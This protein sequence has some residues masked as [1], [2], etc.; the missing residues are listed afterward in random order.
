MNV[1]FFFRIT[2]LSVLLIL[3]GLLDV[4]L[5]PGFSF[6]GEI[7][8]V[9]LAKP[10][11]DKSPAVTS[12]KPISGKSLA[13]TPVIINVD[14]IS[15]ILSLPPV[16]LT[17]Q[18]INERIKFINQMTE[19]A[20]DSKK[21]IVVYYNEA[22]NALKRQQKAVH[23]TTQFSKLMNEGESGATAQNQNLHSLF[24]VG[25]EM[26]AR[27][28]ALSEIESKIVV[29]QTRL[30]EE[31]TNLELT[32]KFQSEI[33]HKP[34]ELRE[35]IKSHETEISKLQSQ[36]SL[37][38]TSNS[39][40]RVIR[41]KQTSLK[42]KLDA[43][44]AELVATEKEAALSKDKKNL[45]ND[46]ISL[47]LKKVDEFKKIIKTW[48]DIKENRQSDLA[49][50][51]I[52]KNKSILTIINEKSF[53]S[54]KLDFLENLC[55]KNLNF[56]KTIISIDRKDNEAEKD[57]VILTERLKQVDTD[58]KITTKRITMMGLTN[59]SGEILLAKRAILSTSYADPTIA[60]KL[61]ENI[62]N[63][64]LSSD[65]MVQE[66]QDFRPFKSSIYNELE[67]LDGKI[68][69]TK[70]L[71][72]TTNVFILLESYR[73]LLAESGKTYTAYLKTLNNLQATQKNINIKSE[74]FRDY[75][76]QRLL[77]TS[78]STTIFKI[79]IWTNS[80]KGIYW[81]VNGY[82]WK[83][84]IKD[85]YKYVVLK[86]IILI[87]ITLSIIVSLLIQLFLPKQIN[88]IN[89][90]SSQPLK[91]SIGRTLSIATLT[92]LQ[93]LC[94]PLTFYLSAL[95]VSKIHSINIFTKAVCFGI[96]GVTSVAFIF[97]L[98]IYFYRKDGICQKNFQWSGKLRELLKKYIKRLFII[99]LPFVFIVVTIQNSPQNLGFR[100][101]LGRLFFILFIFIFLII[102]FLSFK[103][104]KGSKISSKFVEWIQRNYT[105]I[106]I[107][108]ITVLLIL[109]ILSA[110]GYYFTAYE[111]SLN[112]Y[113]T[114][115]FLTVFLFVKDILHRMTYLTQVH[116]AHK[117]A[118]V[119]KKAKQKKKKK[120]ELQQEELTD[121]I[122]VEI[123]D[124]VIGKDELNEQTY[125]L[126][127]F[128]LLI[129]VIIGLLM[130]WSNTFPSIKFLNNVFMWN[131][132]INTVKG[133]KPIM[134]PITLLNLVQG[135]L[136]FVCSIILVKNLP[137]VIEII[138]FR[139][140]DTHPGT[141]HAVILISKY[142]VIC[143]GV[144]V[145]LKFIGIGWAQ[146][147]YIAAALTLGLSFGLQDIFAN[148]VSGIIILIERPIRLGDSVTVAGNTGVI[149]KIRIRSTTITD[150][151]HHELIVP[152]K[153]FLAEKIVNWSLSD[154]VTRIV[155]AVCINQAF[156]DKV[157][158]D[159][160]DNDKDK[161]KDKDKVIKALNRD[162]HSNIDEVEKLLLQV[163]NDNNLVNDKPAPSVIFTGFGADTLDYA[164]RFFVE[165]DK[166]TSVKHKI[167]H[168]IKD[169]FKNAGIDVKTVT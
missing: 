132:D 162:L 26:K 138:V 10:V 6:A 146:F 153:A 116:I 73:K 61:N 164:L 32:L 106:N 122:N 33:I 18:A 167:H 67:K 156:K 49:Y 117:K 50:A 1:C 70:I 142:F 105:W 19:L 87:I 39:S 158:D 100:S 119:E 53:P 41:A 94:I 148:F 23:K 27:S 56:A 66:E 96:T 166:E 120:G 68:S 83:C 51:E 140:K 85:I 20:T 65:D 143:I 157:E 92:I 86:P 22:L 29:F 58:Y 124:S 42:A 128:I 150:G 43:L 79:D 108:V 95:Y 59:K 137:A 104:I 71:E 14:K 121:N 3:I 118:E 9:V 110:A 8:A 109:I 62:L 52:R 38:D 112:I 139:G 115:Y 134:M 35:I 13:T 69:E 57:L 72:L 136:I 25:A 30:A 111:F 90:Y 141:R 127:K 36:L 76:N 47:M 37:P 154:H 131:S 165:L 44:K 145:G 151:N 97:L 125:N 103:K 113:N 163:A 152:N 21:R 169:V 123:T 102:L 84:F 45:I 63:A 155:I 12:T 88:K 74:E 80:L 107:V 89:K 99:T 91:D 16:K 133:G 17:E 161:D 60:K 98:Y 55:E 93:A 7:P 81:L 24:P 46:K 4:L 101:S 54:I 28:M 126:I 135:I 2:K 82:N 78:S 34:A 31:Q 130:I 11:G 144:F 168:E 159:I 64:N 15:K 129:G 147:Q 160:N 77:W 5:V 48:G 40:P 114:I 149:S 75:I